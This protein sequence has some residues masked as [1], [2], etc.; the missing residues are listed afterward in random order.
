M[1]KGEL[2]DENILSGI[3]GGVIGGSVGYKS[4]YAAGYKKKEKEDR[5]T[6]SV[7]QSQL[8]TANQMIE[9]LRGEMEKLQKDNETIRNEKSILERVKGALTA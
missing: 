5:W 3:V 6:I 4:G 1:G 7:L 8:A 2:S 9:S